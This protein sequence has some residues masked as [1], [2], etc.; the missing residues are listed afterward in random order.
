MKKH[1]ELRAISYM[2][3][4]FVI[5]AALLLTVF[6]LLT[7]LGL[8][9]PRQQRLTLHTPDIAKVYDAVALSGSTPQITYGQLHQG[10][11]LEVLSLPQY[12]QVGDYENI[13][14]YRILDETGADVTKQYDITPDYGTVSIQARSITVTSPDKT[15]VYDGTALVSEPVQLSGG[16]L[17]SGHQLVA[18][19]GN[20]L[21]YPGTVAI[22]GAYQIVSETGADVTNQ[23][24]I[25]EQLGTLTVM[26]ITLTLGTESAQKVYDG[27]A[28]TE[29]TWTQ[30]QGSLLA[31]HSIQMNISASL[32]QVGT[33]Q[34]EGIA[35]VWDENG[36]DVTSLYHIQYRFGTLQVQPIQLHILTGS[37]Q[38]VYD[39][40][41]LRCSQWQ[42]LSGALEPGASIQAR[43]DTAVSMVGTT[44]NII[45]FAVVDADGKDI[46]FRYSFVC[47]Y[48]TLSIQPR[49]ITL[50][51]GSAQKIYD[52]EPM[53]CDTF[54]IIQGQLCD[55]EQIQLVG[56]SIVNVGYS[57]NYPLS[58][59]V[60]RL[61]A[62]GTKT[63]VS[64]CYRIS[65]DY[66]LLK[67][68][69]N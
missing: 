66:G 32:S 2:A 26:P 58:C 6:L 31:G 11:R 64:S 69:A 35:T 68:T 5:A 16:T 56:A 39:G 8:I 19:G 40:A 62:D 7:A 61:E 12:T 65:F 42:L 60:Y 21:L 52:G 50:R 57:E 43:S 53:S 27:E 15:K 67:I 20:S 18:Q 59:T 30:L 45:T 3:G 63:D 1:K 13:P 14:V 36:A 23:Y 37:A 9:H 48:G 55:N 34:N 25:N 24:R 28:L 51:T 22:A 41:Q 4:I 44:D 46:S 38:K 54:E 33:A 47:E 49:A 17:A 29:Q 10:H